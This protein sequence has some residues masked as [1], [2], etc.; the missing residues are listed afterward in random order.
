M[1][2]CVFNEL[3]QS[4]CGTEKEV[5]QVFVHFKWWMAVWKGCLIKHLSRTRPW[6]EQRGRLRCWINSM[7]HVIVDRIWC[8]EIKVISENKS[9]NMFTHGKSITIHE[10]WADRHVIRWRIKWRPKWIGNSFCS[11]LR[12]SGVKGS[13]L[14]PAPH[15]ESNTCYKPGYDVGPVKHVTY[16]RSQKMPWNQTHSR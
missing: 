16:M 7:I 1:I 14:P 6:F 8:E 5:M 13:Y 15:H 12:L 3:L 10:G 2:L 11:T 9:S 4:Q